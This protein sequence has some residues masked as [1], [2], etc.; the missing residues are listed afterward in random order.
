MTETRP[1]RSYTHALFMTDSAKDDFLR[2]VEQGMLPITGTA[3][4]K[5]E[6]PVPAPEEAPQLV[7]ACRDNQIV[8][9]LPW[10]GPRGG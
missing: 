3:L 7:V 10:K 4:V 1:E 9:G 2:R 6:E 8:P 5:L